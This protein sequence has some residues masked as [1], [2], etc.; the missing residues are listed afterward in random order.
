MKLKIQGVPTPKPLDNN[1]TNERIM[2]YITD[3]NTNL[4]KDSQTDI[5]QAVKFQ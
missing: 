1:H 5:Y 4:T 2:M 3:V